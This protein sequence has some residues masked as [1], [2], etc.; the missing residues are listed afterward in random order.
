MLGLDLSS[1]LKL[2]LR[3]ALTDK[4]F[5]FVPLVMQGLKL[6]RW[7]EYK[8]G[9][10]WAR[11]YGKRYATAR[12]MHADILKEDSPRSSKLCPLCVRYSLKGR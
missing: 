1:A 10:A 6:K 12:E 11:K 3:H 7:K 2:L 5:S 8:K 4:H 9:I